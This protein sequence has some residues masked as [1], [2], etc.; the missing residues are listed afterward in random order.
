MV[1]NDIEIINDYLGKERVNFK[2]QENEKEN[3]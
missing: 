1:M 2:I 3:I